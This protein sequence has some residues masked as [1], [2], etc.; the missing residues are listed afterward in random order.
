MM[1]KNVIFK[2]NWYFKQNVLIA[3]LKELMWLQMTQNHDR[4][5]SGYS[6]TTARRTMT[7]KSPV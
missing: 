2:G 1:L 7:M 5:N 6:G 3:D 4:Q